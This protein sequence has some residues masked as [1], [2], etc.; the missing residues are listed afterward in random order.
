MQ[1]SARRP[2]DPATIVADGTRLR[3]ELGWT[4]Q[5]DDLDIIV[6]HALAWERRLADTRATAMPRSR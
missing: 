6:E 4:P 1:L 2:D 5:F 3:R